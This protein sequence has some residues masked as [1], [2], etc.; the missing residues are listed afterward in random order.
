MKEKIF[1]YYWMQIIFNILYF[2][3]IIFFIKVG[4][5]YQ[6]DYLESFT[7]SAY[8][9]LGYTVVFPVF[10]GLLMGLP[11]FISNLLG[12]GHWEVDWTKLISIVLPA[13]IITML[14]FI[15]FTPIGDNVVIAFLM[16]YSGLNYLSSYLFNF[17]SLLPQTISGIIFGYL[18]LM[19]ISKKES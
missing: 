18:I 8:F 16:K 12:S 9:C 15:S 14:P 2:F 13:F 11:R 7:V 6:K 19:V 3:F 5:D 10:I 17:S 4:A 1:K